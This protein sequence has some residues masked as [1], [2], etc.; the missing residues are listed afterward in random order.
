MNENDNDLLKVNFKEGPT[1]F[2]VNL[3]AFSGPLDLLCHLVES[4]ELDIA[5]INLTELITQYVEFLLKSEKASLTELV[6]F[7]SFASRLLLRKV[8]SLFP[9]KAIDCLADEDQDE[10]Y[11]EEDLLAAIENFIPYRNAASFLREMQ[12]KREMSFTR[13]HDDDS[14]PFYDLGDLYGLSNK[15]WELL[16]RYKN[17]KP[18]VFFSDDDLW[19]DI[20]DAIPEEKMV[21]QRMEELRLLIKDTNLK[22]SQIL[23]EKNKKNLIVTLLALLELSRMGIVKLIQNEILGEI[24]IVSK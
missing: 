14:A 19:D 10:L 21:D 7:F 24:E 4:R 23:K 13:I 16:E 15:W 12:Q 1:A 17:K 2:N 11:D 22:L 6:E 18:D 9:S 20:P 8:S 5:K 3:D